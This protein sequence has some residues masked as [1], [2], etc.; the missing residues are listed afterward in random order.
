[1]KMLQEISREY[2]DKI[3]ERITLNL[4]NA[5]CEKINFDILRSIPAKTSEMEKKFGLTKMPLNKRLNRL[6]EVGLLKRI[7]HKGELQ[8]THL[9]DKFIGIINM[10]KHDVIKEIP[11]LV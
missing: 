10:I 6:E 8:K 1:M 11:K 3:T 7:K 4:F 2:I 5:G 9:T